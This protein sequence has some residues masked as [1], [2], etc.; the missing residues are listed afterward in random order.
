MDRRVV[1]RDKAIGFEHA[2]EFIKEVVEVLTNKL[3]EV[4]D[5]GLMKRSISTI[6]DSF[7]NYITCLPPSLQDPEKCASREPAAE[8]NIAKREKLPFR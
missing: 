4:V 6:H 5:V 8:K 7:N 1:Y 3:Q 2:E